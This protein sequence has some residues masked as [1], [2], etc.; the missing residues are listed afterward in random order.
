MKVKL[1]TPRKVF[2]QV[3][4]EANRRGPARVSRANIRLIMQDYS[5]MVAALREVHVEIEE[6]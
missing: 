6:D 1:V 2:E 4:E 5:A 3:W